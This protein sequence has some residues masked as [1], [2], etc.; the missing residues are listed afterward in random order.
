MSALDIQ[1][2]RLVLAALWLTT[3]LLSLGIYPLQDSLSLLERVGLHG[4]PALATLYLAA[5]LDF[6][7][8]LLT[9]LKPGKT[10]WTIQAML[11]GVYTLIISFCLPEFWLHPFGPVLKNLP[12]LLLLWLLYKNEGAHS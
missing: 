9:L 3:G 7:L 11:V 10:V 12:I 1:L 5:T 4:I 2:A 6:A 8:G